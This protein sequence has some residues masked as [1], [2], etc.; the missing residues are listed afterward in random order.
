VGEGLGGAAQIVETQRLLAQR[1]QLLDVGVDAF[2]AGQLVDEGLDLAVGNGA[3]EAVDR[4][5]VDEGVDGRDRLHPQLARIGR[6][7]VDVDLDHLHRPLGGAHGLLQRGAERPAR[8]APGRPEVDDD[9]LM[10]R[11]LDHVGHEGG[12]RAVL[13]QVGR[14]GQG[15]VGEGHGRVCMGVEGR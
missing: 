6:V 15:R 2:S 10:L 13:D 12:V 14:V 9:R 4:L 5:A 1:Q 8:A 3:L 7:G 11:G